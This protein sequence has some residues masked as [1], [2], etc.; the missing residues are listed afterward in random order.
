MF[1]SDAQLQADVIDEIRWD[2]SAGIPEVGV[3]VKNG[4]VTLSGQVDSYARRYAVV[5]AA[6]R[7][8]GVRAVAEEVQVVLP[9]SFRRTDTDVAHAVTRALT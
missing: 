2:P 4:V 6:E 7:V 1:K 9:M 3:A 8:A 5:R